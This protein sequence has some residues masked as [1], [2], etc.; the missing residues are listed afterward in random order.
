MYQPRLAHLGLIVLLVAA[1]CSERGLPSEPVHSGDLPSEPVHSGDPL[2]AVSDGSHDG[3]EGFYFLAPMVKNPMYS[4]TFDPTL[5]PVVEICETT[6]CTEFH[7]TFS[8]TEGAGSELVRLDEEAERYV[9]NWHTDKTGPDGTGTI[10]GQTY[11]VRVQVAGTVLGYADV[12][13]AENGKEA[14]NTSS[15]D[16]IGLVDGRTLPIQFRVEEGTVSVIGSDGGTFTSNAGTVTIEV[17]PGAVEGDIGIMVTLITEGLDD[18]DVVPGLAFE[19]LPSPYT[20]VEPVIVTVVYDP[21]SLPIG[22]SEDELR[23]LAFVG[24]EWV[25][26]PG[27]SVDVANSTVSGPL[28]SF[29]RKAVGRAKVHAISVSPEEASIAL[30]ETQQFMETVTDVDGEVLLRNV[31]W[32]S[33]DA[34]VATVDADGLATGQAEGAATITATAGPASG[35]AAIAVQSANDPFVTTWD[36]NRGSG[37][38]VSLA[39]AG[40]VDATIDWG[41]GTITAVN[42]PGPHTH[43]Y[44]VNGIYSVSV[45]GS[46]TGYNG[47]DNG[48]DASERAK[49][50]SVDSWGELGF[51][52]LQWAF[53]Q[54]VNLTS[55][56][57]D[58]DGIEAVTNMVAMFRMASAFNGDIGGWNTSSVTNMNHMFNQASAF[59]QDIGGWDTSSVTSMGLMFSGASS[60]NQDIGR[61]N[62]S[63]VSN[64]TNMFRVATA[65][66]QDLSVWCVTLIASE[67]ADFDTAASNWVL[68]RPI[69][70]TCPS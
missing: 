12:Q 66:N 48:G 67:P 37:T 59:N 41:D 36:T 18:P 56:P 51:T 3:I 57:A 6:A 7:E 17:P 31:Q 69:W 50:I 2:H 5:S 49:L 38:T 62:T 40:A 58:T 21:L 32:S 68:P 54:A 22:I 25:Q 33:S 11:R 27:S 70:G 14:R 9:V 63:S 8:M 60:F 20:F 15:D 65:F 43:D 19:F 28:D 45:T 52:S 42:A 13:M 47:F 16:V 53:Y 46:V 34:G 30:G 10:V 24:D 23:L 1:G 26:L 61:W 64:M 35:S 29:S 4:G 39:L 44:S 55:V